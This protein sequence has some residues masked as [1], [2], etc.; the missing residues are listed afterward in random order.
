MYVCVCV[1][2]SCQNKKERE[3]QILHRS[4]SFVKSHHGLVRLLLPV[5]SRFLGGPSEKI[6]YETRRL[7]KSNNNK[8]SCLL[9]KRKQ[10]S[11]RKKNRRPNFQPRWR[12]SRNPQ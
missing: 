10:A 6:I 12:A 3:N 5:K 8:K 9:C 2:L 11:V 4:C 7:G 1:L